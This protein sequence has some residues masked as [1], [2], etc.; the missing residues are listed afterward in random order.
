VD[1]PR[2]DHRQRPR[3]PRQTGQVRVFGRLAEASAHE[4]NI[5]V[6]VPSWTWISSR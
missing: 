1:R 3:Q 6:C 2:V 4:Q 5:F